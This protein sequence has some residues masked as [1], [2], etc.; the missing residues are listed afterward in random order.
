MDQGDQKEIQVMEA[1]FIFS[2]M[3]FKERAENLLV[4][5]QVNQVQKDNQGRGDGRDQW[6]PGGSLDR[7]VLERKEIKVELDHIYLK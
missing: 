2:V 4:S 3:K 7:L 5:A 6:V 1:L